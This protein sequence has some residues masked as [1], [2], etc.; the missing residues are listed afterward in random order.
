M[1]EGFEIYVVYKR[2]YIN[3][4]LF[5]S[6]PRLQADYNYYCYCYYDYCYCY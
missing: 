6:F 4:L 1:P 3:T 2:R 5:L